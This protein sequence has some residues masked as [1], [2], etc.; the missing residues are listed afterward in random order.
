LIV[1]TNIVEKPVEKIVEKII[2]RP[3]VE[4]VDKYIT[5]IVNAE[6]PPQYK[7]AF[8]VANNILNAEW[9]L[10]TN[11]SKIPYIESI[12]VTAVVSEQLTGVISPDKLKEKLELELR[13]A[14]IKI[15]DSPEAFLNAELLAFEMDNK[16]E[17]VYTYKLELENMVYI[18]DWKNDIAYKHLVPIWSGSSFGIAGKKILNQSFV[19]N[20]FTEESDKIINKLLDAKDKQATRK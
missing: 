7:Y 2:E 6:I 8:K 17:H 15:S 1:K 18:Y 12:N 5:N 14:G 3:V 9:I 16:Q 19:N 11:G 13:K 20:K 10:G 4:Y